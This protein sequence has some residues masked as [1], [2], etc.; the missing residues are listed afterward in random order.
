MSEKPNRFCKD[1]IHFLPAYNRN[2]SLGAMC[3]KIQ[4]I[5]LVLGTI[6]H[7]ACSTYRNDENKC[8]REGNW[9]SSVTILHNEN[10]QCSP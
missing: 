3:N 1:C 8:G 10:N 2:D 7:G 9:W 6:G 4:I 5:N